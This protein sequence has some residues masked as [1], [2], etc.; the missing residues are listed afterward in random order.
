MATSL[1]DGRKSGPSS[2]SR[3][4]P[5]FAHGLNEALCKRRKR[6]R[7]GSRS[8]EGLRN[9]KAIDSQEAPVHGC[10]SVAT[11]HQGK[12]RQPHLHAG[13]AGELSGSCEPRTGRS[14]WP[15]L[16]DYSGCLERVEWGCT[17]WLGGSIADS[18][19]PSDPLSPTTHSSHPLRH[20]ISTG[21]QRA[22]ASTCAWC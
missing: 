21:Q 22:S 1:L 20:V 10:W 6:R 14:T 12:H 2:A 17:S 11:N 3:R 16:Q 18:R 13:A 7:H 4:T 19:F 5:R 15:L 9:K 8:S